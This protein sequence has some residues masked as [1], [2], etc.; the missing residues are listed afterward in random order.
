MLL[1]MY[2][3]KVWKAT[4][5]IDA[6]WDNTILNLDLLQPNKSDALR[7]LD[8]GAAAPPRYAQATLQFGATTK[9]YIREYMVGPLPVTK[10]KTTV[11]PLD[12]I[13]NKG[14][15]VQRVYNADPVAQQEFGLQ[16]GASIQNVTKKL[17]NGVCN[18]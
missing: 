17:L 9:P 6:S 2:R 3:D 16:V 14:Q 8:S 13:Y 18:R 5:S 11:A 7:F 12:Y 15:G 1:G 4:C 10:G